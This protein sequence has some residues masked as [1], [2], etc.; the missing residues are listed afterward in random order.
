MSDSFTPSVDH[1]VTPAFTPE[2]EAQLLA[3]GDITKEQVQH[4]DAV[5][6]EE[7]AELILGKFKSQEE[8]IK[9]YE[10]LEQKLSEPGTPTGDVGGLLTEAGDYFN[11]NGELAESHY[12]QFANNG[13]PRE[14]VDRYMSGMQA[15]ADAEAAQLMGTIG[16]QE[17]FTQMTTWMSESLPETE[18]TAYNNVVEKGTNEEVAVLIQGMHARFKAAT[19]TGAT[20]LKGQTTQ[21]SAGF[22]SRG[23]VMAAMSSN[24]YRTDEAYRADVER[25]LAATPPNVF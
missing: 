5:Q 2:Q 18:I 24:Q 6:P 22:R 1:K 12:E 20:Q 11:E 7:Q 9:A 23:E 10:G 4:P 13:I 8:L 14:Y 21:A 19:G 15:T 3:D 16:G 25:K 17:Q